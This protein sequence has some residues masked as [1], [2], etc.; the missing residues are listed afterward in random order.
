MA[1]VPYD[2]MKGNTVKNVGKPRQ[3]DDA[4][5]WSLPAYTTAE[6][7]ALD[8]TDSGFYPIIINTTTAKINFYVGG[9]WRVVTST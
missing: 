1:V 6:R 7:D 4:L 8:V 9:A 3:K 5:T 2:N